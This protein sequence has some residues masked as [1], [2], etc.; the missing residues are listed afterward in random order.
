MLLGDDK[1]CQSQQGIVLSGYGL[2]G[3]D[4]ITMTAFLSERMPVPVLLDKT[5]IK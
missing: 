2:H 4:L 5:D 3:S 1:I